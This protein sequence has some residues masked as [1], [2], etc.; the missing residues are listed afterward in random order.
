MTE[1]GTAVS[2]AV[3]TV[4]GD[5]D[6]HGAGHHPV[7]IATSPDGSIA[8][9][10]AYVDNSVTLIDTATNT[11][12]GAPI[13]VGSAQCLAAAGRERVYVTNQ[14]G[15]SVSAITPGDGHPGQRIA[16]R[17]GHNHSYGRWSSL[18]AFRCGS[19]S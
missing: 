6:R 9:L 18:E 3:L 14:G 16:V 17:Y 12:I 19:S 2:S 1:P 10:T 4:L 5:G 11:A 7:G 8:C 13:R 15:D